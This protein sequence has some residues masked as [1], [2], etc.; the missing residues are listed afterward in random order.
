[1]F[2]A[3]S[4]F[5]SPSPGGMFGSGLGNPGSSLYGMP[6]QQQQP[7][8]QVPAQAALQAHMEAMN[9]AETQKIREELSKLYASFTGQITPSTS[10][11]AKNNFVSIVY[12]DVDQEQRQLQWLHGMGANGQVMAIAPPK[13]PQVSE[14]EWYKAVAH[15]PDPMNYMPV[16]LVGAD[17]LNARLV[18]QQERA[19]QL[20]RDAATIQDSHETARHL[21]EQAYRRIEKIQ[22]DHAHNRRRLLNIM[23][24]VEVV[25]GMNVPLQREE[26]KAMEQLRDMSLKVRD[27]KQQIVQL[28]KQ[29]RVPRQIP[30][31]FFKEVAVFDREGLSKMFTEH[32][33]VIKKLRT[34]LSKDTRDVELIKQQVMSKE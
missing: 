14:E 19:A 12:N 10:S 15:N 8:P 26:V 9:A 1:M 13:P 2:G 23:R 29:A 4:T 25:R 6:Q 31:D 17:A 34:S 27:L 33:E 24:K 30:E 11:N 5:G 21:N 7:R 32:G 28:E 16:A 3:T 20:A 22:R 18:W